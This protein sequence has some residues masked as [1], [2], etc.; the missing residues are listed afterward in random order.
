VYAGTFAATHVAQ[1]D[2]GGKQWV[3]ETLRLLHA[4]GATS[5]LAKTSLSA[6]TPLATREEAIVRPFGFTSGT[7]WDYALIWY[8]MNPTART[9]CEVI[10][11]ADLVAT[12]TALRSS[13]TGITYADRKFQEQEDGTA[14]FIVLFQKV[15]WL[16]R[17]I[18]VVGQTWPGVTQTTTTATSSAWSN[19][20]PA[21]KSMAS[22]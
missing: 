16:N 8:D 2:D 22:D 5:A 1:R 21:P 19:V 15:S 12:A 7:K 18:A 20:L 6:L 9:G 13:W 4:V 14:V 11:A 17:W 3:V 10:T